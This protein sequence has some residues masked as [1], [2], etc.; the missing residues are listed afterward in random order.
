MLFTEGR[1]EQAY[2]GKETVCQKCGCYIYF[3]TR[4]NEKGEIITKDGLL[5]NGKQKPDSNLQWF[6]MN[7]FNN[8]DHRCLGV[9]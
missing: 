6:C 3:E 7:S 2:R 4:F 1:K 5:P 9:G 8:T